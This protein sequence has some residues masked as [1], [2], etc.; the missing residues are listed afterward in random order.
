VTHEHSFHL[1]PTISTV[2]E[3]EE[4]LSWWLSN[5]EPVLLINTFFKFAF[6][7]ISIFN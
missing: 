7:L 5:F 4:T 6:F 2:E 3:I 1:P